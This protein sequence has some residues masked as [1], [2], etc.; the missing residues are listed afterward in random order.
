MGS[1]R[2]RMLEKNSRCGKRKIFH[3]DGF[4]CRKSC[5]ISVKS[6]LNVESTIYVS[7]LI[8][9]THFC[10]K[11]CINFNPVI[12]RDTKSQSTHYLYNREKQVFLLI[13]LAFKPLGKKTNESEVIRKSQLNIPRK[14]S[15][16]C[17]DCTKYTSH[18]EPNENCRNCRNCNY[19]ISY[20]PPLS[21]ILV[22]S[23]ASITSNNHNIHINPHV[24]QPN[25]NLHLYFDLYPSHPSPETSYIKHKK[26]D[27]R[28]NLYFYLHFMLH[29]TLV[30]R[31]ADEEGCEENVDET[32]EDPTALDEQH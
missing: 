21:R 4:Y 30:H 8:H 19:C 1:Q 7:H 10:Y 6:C 28:Y 15:K 20:N 12:I 11:K 9:L 2:K 16:S 26:D 18:N 25:L 5:L 22:T 14:N 31:N 3:N 23:V 32:R 29:T 24:K 17:K 13:K 27:K